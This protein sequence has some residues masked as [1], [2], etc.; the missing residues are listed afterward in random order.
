MP[1]SVKK[2]LMDFCGLDSSRTME[3]YSVTE[4]SKPPSPSSELK[5]RESFG[6]TLAPDIGAPGFF[7]LEEGFTWLFEMECFDQVR[8]RSGGGRGLGT[9]DGEGKGEEAL[10]A[11][12]ACLFC[13]CAARMHTFY[14][15]H[16][17]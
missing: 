15:E 5:K 8:R 3:I 7:D 2:F 12:P 10:K 14:T 16:E 1:S 11:L 13:L 9:A 4:S 17:R 6:L